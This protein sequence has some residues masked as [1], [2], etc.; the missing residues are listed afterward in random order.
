MQPHAPRSG[1]V[2]PQFPSLGSHRPGWLLRLSAG[3]PQLWAFLLH[4]FSPPFPPALHFDVRNLL[5][6]AQPLL[7]KPSLGGLSRACSLLPFASSAATLLVLVGTVEAG[8]QARDTVTQSA[9][10]VA[11]T[12]SFGM[13]R[14]DGAS[15]RT[16]PGEGNE[17]RTRGH[18]ANMRQGTAEPMGCRKQPPCPRHPDGSFGPDRAFKSQKLQNNLFVPCKKCSQERAIDC[19]GALEVPGLCCLPAHSKPVCFGFIYLKRANIELC[20][21]GTG[22]QGQ[23]A[24]LRRAPNP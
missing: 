14:W 18:S 1:L 5:P 17:P 7:C 22:G 12:A 3:C 10:M 6:S 16:K 21:H 4:P 15:S 13:S 2:M 11:A 24:T 9:W 8:E 23:A 20:K 19:C